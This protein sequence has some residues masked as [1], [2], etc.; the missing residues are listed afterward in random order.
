MPFKPLFGYKNGYK[1]A[2]ACHT[3]RMRI[4]KKRHS[5]ACL[6]IAAF[7][8]FLPALLGTK[9]L[10]GSAQNTENTERYF[11]VHADIS[12]VDTKKKLVALTFDDA[13]KKTLSSILQ[14][15]AEYNENHASAPAAATLFCNGALFDYPA[16]DKLHMAH[17][18]G[19][20]LGNHGYTHANLVTLSGEA[21]QKELYQTDKYLQR[22]DGKPHHLFRPPFGNVNAEMRALVHA[23]VIHWSIDTR[24]WTGID[25][26]ALIDAATCNLF[27]GAIV[28][29][30]DGFESTAYCIKGLLYKLESMGYQAVTVSQLAAAHNQTLVCGG[31]YGRLRKATTKI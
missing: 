29:M 6:L 11:A 26:N 4:S 22:I 18:L 24:D 13:P 9:T 16:I 3:I 12:K 8:F 21:L 31:V 25:G 1:I 5:F 10:F 2:A 28:L 14:A 15:F 30:H 19:F 7:F 23:P 17:A 27:D 20:E